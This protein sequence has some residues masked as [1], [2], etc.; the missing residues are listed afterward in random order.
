MS[1]NNVWLDSFTVLYVTTDTACIKCYI[2]VSCGM[3]VR[4]ANQIPYV[5]RGL[6]GSKGAAA[7]RRRDVWTSASIHL[8]EEWQRQWEYRS[9]AAHL[10][11]FSSFF[12]TLT[13]HSLSLLS[14][15]RE[16]YK[17]TECEGGWIGWK[18]FCYKLESGTEEKLSQHDAQNVCKM[19]GSQ[20][21]S[22]HS[23]ED[24]EMLHTNFHSGKH[25]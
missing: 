19:A 13:A 23:L 4:H 7:F 8:H 20:L 24:I 10:F 16:V 6:W 18:G 17:P 5:G 15:A 25:V 12:L 14:A 2:C 22:I 11:C 9:D 3:F 1:E 21:A